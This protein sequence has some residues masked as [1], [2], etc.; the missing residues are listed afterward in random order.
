MKV[1]VIKGG[2]KTGLSNQ[3]N[4]QTGSKSASGAASSAS[5]ANSAQFQ[6]LTREPAVRS[7]FTTNSRPGGSSQRLSE[8]EAFKTAEDLA[9]RI[10][11]DE[12]TALGAH[13]S[14][15]ARSLT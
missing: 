9:D 11:D 2:V 3:Q 12:D 8:D 4:A 14:I 7:L 10:K 1:E 15:T 6:A 5:S 13:D